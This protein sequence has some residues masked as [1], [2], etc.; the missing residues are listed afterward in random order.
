MRGKTA[1]GR[2][3]EDTCVVFGRVVCL[4]CPE[5]AIHSLTLGTWRAPEKPLG[6]A[7]LGVPTRMQLLFV[8][9]ALSCYPDL[10]HYLFHRTE[11]LA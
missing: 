3:L 6:V 11:K 4:R 7:R 1:A 2:R 8:V 5:K 10:V 9:H